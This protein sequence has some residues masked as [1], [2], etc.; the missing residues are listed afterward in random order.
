MIDW[1]TL[2]ER[3]AKPEEWD[4]FSTGHGFVPD[5]S[6]V[7]YVGQMNI[8]PGWWNDET[9]LAAAS[10]LLSEAEFDVRYP[11]WESVQEMAYTQIPAI[12]IGDSSNVSFRSESIGGWDG[13]FER[14]IKFWNLWLNES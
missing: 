7:S 2:L 3:R 13:Q 1:A 10:E 5:P 12:K 4:M 9:A 11:I 8:Y 6:Q 14:G